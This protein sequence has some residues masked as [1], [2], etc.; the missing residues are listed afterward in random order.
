MGLRVHWDDGENG[1]DGQLGDPCRGRGG[2]GSRAPYAVTGPFHVSLCCRR[3]AIEVLVDEE[4]V[5]IRTPFEEA[6]SRGFQQGGY[7]GITQ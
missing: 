3:T 7:G 2:R 4:F 6:A 5:D 1:W